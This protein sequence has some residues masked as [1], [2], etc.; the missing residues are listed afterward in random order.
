[1]APHHLAPDFAVPV[2]DAWVVPGALAVPTELMLVSRGDVHSALPADAGTRDV[3]AGA[4]NWRM[5]VKGF[6][7]GLGIVFGSAF[8]LLFGLLF[9]ESTWLGPVVGVS[10]GLIVGAVIDART[11][12]PTE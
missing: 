12:H 10:I 1:V 8:G 7:T 2:S 6:G 4:V 11:H 9:L 3:D 5:L